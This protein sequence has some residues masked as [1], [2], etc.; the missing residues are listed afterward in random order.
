MTD[1][2]VLIN[3]PANKLTDAICDAVIQEAVD[4]ASAIGITSLMRGVET[5]LL[6]KGQAVTRV[7]PDGSAKVINIDE[8]RPHLAGPAHCLACKHKWVSVVPAAEGNAWLACPNCERE[9]GHLDWHINPNGAVLVCRCG[10]DLF[11]HQVGGSFC[12][13]C[14]NFLPND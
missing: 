13:S 12:P 4:A 2:D 8:F 10:N 14:G 9:M 1:I 7:A 11:Y 3:L 5:D 6:T